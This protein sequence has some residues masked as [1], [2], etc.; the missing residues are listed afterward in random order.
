VSRIVGNLLVAVT[1]A[2]PIP[3]TWE[4]LVFIHDDTVTGLPLTFDWAFAVI[5]WFLLATVFHRGRMVIEDVRDVIRET[6]GRGG[7]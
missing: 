2:I 4:Y 3:A 5:L 1:F 7:S 6:A